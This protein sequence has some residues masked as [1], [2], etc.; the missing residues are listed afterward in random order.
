MDDGGHSLVAGLRAGRAAAFDELYRRHHERI[1]AFLARLTGDRA[2]AEDLY[3][4]TW[5]AAAR[6]AHELPADSALLPWLYTVA[7]NKHRSSRRAR[8]YDGERKQRFGSEPTAPT[9]APDELAAVHAESAA[10][11][12]GFAALSAEHREVLLLCLVEGLATSEVGQVLGL[13]DAAVRKRLSRARAELAG[14]LAKAHA[15]KQRS[16]GGAP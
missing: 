8:R 6:H 11:A 14:L 2:E 16:T 12:R 1:W 9:A 7:R 5:L 3:Q 13:N 15:S 4:E 10:L